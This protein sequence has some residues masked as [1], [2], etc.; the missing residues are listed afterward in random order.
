[1]NNLPGI[2]SMPLEGTYLAWVDFS[3][4]GMSQKD[5]LLRV[6]KEAMIAVNHGVTFGLGGEGF[7]RFNLATPRSVVLRAIERLNNAFCDLQ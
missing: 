6:E 2:K 5:I 3:S 4:T 1:M 7:L